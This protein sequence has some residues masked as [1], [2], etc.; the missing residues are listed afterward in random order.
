[1][2]NRIFVIGDT[3]FGHK[4][5]AE[6]RGFDSIEAHD[7]TLVEN[8]NRAVK[9]KDTVWHLGD[10][11]FGKASFAILGRLNGLKSLVMG[12]HDRYP[13]AMYLEHFRGIYGAVE[14]KNHL[15]TH[16]PVHHG[17]SRRYAGNIHG[18][19]HTNQLVEPWYYCVSAER[20][21]LTPIR[22]DEVT[23]RIYNV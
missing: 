15:L 11:L 9:P 8:W 7:E 19:L 16:I 17:Q 22:L 14:L 21:D 2:S 3:H 6:V 23:A 4:K 5:I 13:S 12:N 1:M 10:V 20:I 18:H